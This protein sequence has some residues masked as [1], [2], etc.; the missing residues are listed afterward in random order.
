MSLWLRG[1]HQFANV[2]ECAALLAALHSKWQANVVSVNPS[3]YWVSKPL[4]PEIRSSDLVLI[5]ESP[6]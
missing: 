5:V 1:C 2:S 4:F 6:H 3:H